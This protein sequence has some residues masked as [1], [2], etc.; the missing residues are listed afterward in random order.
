MTARRKPTLAFWL[1]VVLVAC[2]SM[3]VLYVASFGPAC[4]WFT[5]R[6]DPVAPQAYWPI[7]WLALNCPEPVGDIAWWYALM[8][9]NAVVVPTSP[10]GEAI[11]FARL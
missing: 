5:D 9:T 11:W 8:G 4:W 2:V 6:T 1:T 7:G 3:P 10:D